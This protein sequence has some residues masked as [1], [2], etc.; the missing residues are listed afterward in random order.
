M[1]P[2]AQLAQDARLLHLAFERFES[3]VDPVGIAEDDFWH[4]DL[5]GLMMMS[6]SIWKRSP[7]IGERQ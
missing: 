7:S 2:A 5:D 3:P 4:V 1:A 6:L